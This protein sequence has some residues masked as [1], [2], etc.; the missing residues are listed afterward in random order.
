M[1]DTTH[2]QGFSFLT[3]RHALIGIGAFMVAVVAV[4]GTGGGGM[5]WDNAMTQFTGAITGPWAGGIALLAIAFA[6]GALLMG[7]ELA[8][9]GRT[10]IFLILGLGVILGAAQI[11][12][13]FGG[14][15]ALLPAL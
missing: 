14:A 2:A 13:L 12:A 3:K 7:G 11:V 4:A 1:T 9:F 10:M 5:P 15:G 8:G 6:V